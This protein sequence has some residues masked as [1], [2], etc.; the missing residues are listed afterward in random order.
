MKAGPRSPIRRRRTSIWAVSVA[1]LAVAL[2][3]MPAAAWEPTTTA[4]DLPSTQIGVLADMT[5]RDKVVA[6]TFDIRY[7]GGGPFG[8]PYDAGVAWSTDAGATWSSRNAGDGTRSTE[9]AVVVCRRHVVVIQVNDPYGTGTTGIYQDAIKLSDSTFALRYWATVG[10]SRR[11]RH[12]DVTCMG[13]TKL[14]VAWFEERSSGGYTVKLRTGRHGA[15]LLDPTLDLGAGAAGRGLSVV[16]T[17]DRLYV[18]WFSGNKLRL[19]RFKVGA[20]PD[21]PIAKL[22]IATVSTAAGGSDPEIGAEGSRVFLAYSHQSDLKIR[23][24]T[25]KGV[26]FGAV[27]KLRNLPAAPAYRARPI[28]VA[29]S[30]SSVVIGAVESSTSKPWTGKGLGFRSTDGGASYLRVTTQSAGRV[31]ATLATIDGVPRYEEA[32][33]QTFE[34]QGVGA[35]IRFRR[36]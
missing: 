11:V 2:A 13:D 1:L 35:L 5:A 30:G 26:S 33:D 10:H 28:T 4:R 9:P 17:T 22:G 34:A 12:P 32:W 18:T 27:T 15:N 36:E 16:A 3:S 8:L 6:V 23:R 31:A 21:Y 19:A 14:A 25:N 29:V 7:P 20:A 24:S